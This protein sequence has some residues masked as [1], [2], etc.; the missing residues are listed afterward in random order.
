MRYKKPIHS[1]EMSVD[2][3]YEDVLPLS[4]EKQKALLDLI[5]KRKSGII[6]RDELKRILFADQ[7]STMLH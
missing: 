1:M 5:S 7:V 2:G 6:S 3:V 4:M